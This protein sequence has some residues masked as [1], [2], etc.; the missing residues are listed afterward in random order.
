MLWGV[1]VKA[2]EKWRK[3]LRED[4]GDALVDQSL[5]LARHFGAQFLKFQ[6]RDDQE[7]AELSRHL[8]TDKML[9]QDAKA[10]LTELARAK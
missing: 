4:L 1:S 2:L 3:T 10:L 8:F 7:R 6:S 5:H 9:H